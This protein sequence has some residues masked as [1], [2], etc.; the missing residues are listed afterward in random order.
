MGLRCG[1]LRPRRRICSRRRDEIKNNESSGLRT[2]GPETKNLVQGARVAVKT[3]G[4][5]IE[6]AL[7]P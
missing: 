4:L 2:D 3:R 6:S 7:L 5:K 1:L